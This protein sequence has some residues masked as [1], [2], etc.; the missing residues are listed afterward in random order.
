MKAGKMRWRITL[1]KPDREPDGQGGY[2]KKTGSTGFADAATVW[3]EFRTPNVKE[4]AATGTIVSDLIR[5]ITIRRRAD[6]RRGWHVL[7]DKR[8]F[9]VLHVYEYDSFTTALVC[10]EVIK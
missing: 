9:E 1:Q 4:Q 8:T 10:K 6:I 5:S 2:K 3:A 7:Y